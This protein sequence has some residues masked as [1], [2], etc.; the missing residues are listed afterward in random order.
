MPTNSKEYNAKVYHKYWWRPEEIARRSARNKARR[1]KWL[2]VWDPR[3]VDHKNGNPQDNSPSNLRVIS[4]R[5]NR[6][7]WA[8]KA[9]M[10]K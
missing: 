3:E 8:R 9:N 4:R 1:K 5:T 10:R 6:I 7:L 2:A